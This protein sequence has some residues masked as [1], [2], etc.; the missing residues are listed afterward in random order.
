LANRSVE[1]VDQVV[2]SL[3]VGR[4]PDIGRWS[5]GRRYLLR[6]AGFYGN[7]K[8]GSRLWCTMTNDHPLKRPYFPEMIALYMWREFGFDLVN[9]LS[10]VRGGISM[11]SDAKTSLG[12]GNSSGMGM[13]AVLTRW[14]WWVDA[15]T[16]TR[17]V[18]R[19]VIGTMRPSE[20]PNLVQR[21]V[22][23][24]DVR[25]KQF[26]EDAHQ[27]TSEF[28]ESPASVA[29]QLTKVRKKI[30]SSVSIPGTADLQEVI[31][32]Y[33]DEFLTP[34]ANESVSAA[35]IDAAPDIADCGFRAMSQLME[36]VTYLDPRQE[37]SA[38]KEEVRRRYDWIEL[39]DVVRESRQEYFWYKSSD[40][41]EHRRGER[42]TDSGVECEVLVDVASEVEALLMTCGEMPENVSVGQL[43]RDFPEYR[44]IVERVHSLRRR[45]YGDIRDRCTRDGFLPLWVIRFYLTVLG[46][47]TTDPKNW[48]WVRG[49]FF[50]DAPLAARIE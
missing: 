22:S 8:Q 3:E 13:V 50:R 18:C 10:R 42:G 49:V 28:I 19:A 38:F 16:V 35:A 44:E 40:N 14:P 41:G 20:E 17:E 6:N 31:F 25:Q 27:S 34:E 26:E 15:W 7:G 11:S 46:L 37:M 2:S 43:L 39:R 45:D 29:K 32:Q 1:N 30:G 5:P 9:H 24:L 47:Q 48:R 36:P 33:A 12:I 23:E 4:Q 21:F